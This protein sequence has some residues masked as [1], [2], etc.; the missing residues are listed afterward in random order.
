MV[1]LIIITLIIN[2]YDISHIIHIILIIPI[3]NTIIN[4]II[5]NK[6][7]MIK[8]AAALS[9]DWSVVMF[10]IPGHNQ[11]HRCERHHQTNVPR[12]GKRNKLHNLITPV[13]SVHL[14]SGDL[15]TLPPKKHPL[16][17]ST[18]INIGTPAFFEMDACQL[19]EKNLVTQ[20]PEELVSVTRKPPKVTPSSLLVHRNRS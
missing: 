12:L 19:L 13:L 15:T 14:K 1:S 20:P 9:Y 18:N 7:Q 10:I 17:K 5:Q 16:I 6:H 11:H 2:I 8:A 3:I 4:I